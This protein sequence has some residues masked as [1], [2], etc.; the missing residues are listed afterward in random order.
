MPLSRPLLHPLAG[1]RPADLARVLAVHGGIAPTR[2]GQ[3][4]LL[5]LC[6][7]LNAPFSW[8][9][10]VR[11]RAAARAPLGKPPIF[12]IGHWRSGTTLLH[13]LL[14]RDERFCF[15]TITDALRPHSFYPSPFEFISR[16]L[17]LLS[18]PAVR[19]MDDVPVG[20]DLPQEDEFAL[21]AMGAPSFLNCLYFPARMERIFCQEVLFEGAPM[22]M[23]ATWRAGLKCYFGKLSALAPGRQLLVKNPA[24]SARIDELC[25]LFP[26]AKF[27][28]I[29]REPIA[30]LASTRKLYRRMLPL[31]ALQSYEMDRIEDHIAHAY[32]RLIDALQAGMSRVASADRIDLGYADLLADPASALSRIYRHFDL[33]GFESVWPAMR[34]MLESGRPMSQS[35]DA[36]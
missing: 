30:V 16:K 11:T 21:A 2:A 8:V 3:V 31:V 20:E 27:I 36:A 29:H 28:H 35:T 25:G 26:G 32:G 13:N 9:E 18:L 33:T 10:A 15:P 19:P 4:G 14:S 5:A 1:S 34:Q 24:H 23:I 7:V 6:C 17:L 12:I 22:Q